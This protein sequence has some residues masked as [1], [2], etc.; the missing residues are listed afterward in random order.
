M[1][2]KRRGP[3]PQVVAVGPAAGFEHLERSALA[4]LRWLT[5]AGIQFVLVGPVAEAIRGDRGARGPVAIVPAPYARNLE[6]LARALT[7]RG[8]TLRGDAASAGASLRRRGETLQLTADGLARGRRWLLRFAGYDLDVECPRAGAGA[9]A[10]STDGRGAPGYREL[11]YEASAFE[12]AGGVV[13]QVAA[14]EDLVHYDHVRRTGGPPRLS[15]ARL[16]GGA[17]A[18][19]RA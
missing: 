8:A 12:P 2:I 14:P 3:A 15:V 7:A 16:A 4:V 9:A 11:L 18:G 19:R 6:R 5:A 17:A 13:V 10:G 1:P